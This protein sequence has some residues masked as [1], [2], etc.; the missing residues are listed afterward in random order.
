MFYLIQICYLKIKIK[1]FLCKTK[2]AIGKK[3]HKNPPNKFLTRRKRVFKNGV[4]CL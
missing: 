3:I 2:F 1:N 4:I